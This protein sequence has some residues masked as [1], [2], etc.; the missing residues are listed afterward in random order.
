M[1]RRNLEIRRGTIHRA[2]DYMYRVLD[3]MYRALRYIYAMHKI[4]LYCL[5]SLQ[6]LMHTSIIY[7]ISTSFKTGIV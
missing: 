7:V 6:K 1:V 3:Y 4:I 5:I 2:L